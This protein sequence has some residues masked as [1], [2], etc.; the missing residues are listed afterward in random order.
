MTMGA[1]F[2]YF[3][4]STGSDKSMKLKQSKNV[5][6]LSSLSSLNLTLINYVVT[7][8]GGGEGVLQINFI[9]SVPF[10]FHTFF[11]KYSEKCLLLLKTASRTKLNQY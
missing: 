8:S 7:L 6:Y 4:S 1:Y 9:F 3:I 10:L 5:K 2:W 11:I